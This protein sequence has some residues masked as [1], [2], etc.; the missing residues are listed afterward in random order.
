MLNKQPPTLPIQNKAENED[1]QTQKDY[2]QSEVEINPD[3]FNIIT[4]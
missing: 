3:E 1:P 4:V 2:Q